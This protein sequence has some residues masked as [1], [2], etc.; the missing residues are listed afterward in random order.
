VPATKAGR[1]RHP[2]LALAP[3]LSGAAVAD[4]AGRLRLPW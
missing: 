2:V 1:Q 4:C 3:R